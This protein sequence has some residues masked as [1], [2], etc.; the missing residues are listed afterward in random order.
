[1]KPVLDIRRAD[2]ISPLLSFKCGVKSMDD[3]IH[4]HENGLA[5]FIMLRL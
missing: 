1:M 5:K 2:D 4:D 3:F